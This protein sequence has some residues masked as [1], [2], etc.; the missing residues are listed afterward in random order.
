MHFPAWSI[1]PFVGLLICIAVLPLLPQSARLW[2]RNTVKAAVA[3]GLG[4][5]VAAWVTLRGQSDLVV[6]SVGEYIQFIVLIGALFVVSGG[7]HLDGRIAASPRNNTAILALGGVLASLIGTTGAAMLLIR[8]LLATNAHRK[9]RAHTV[10]FAILVIANCGGLLTPLGDPPLYIGFMR[11]VPFT[12]TLALTGP[13]LFINGMLLLTYYSLDR[14]QWARDPLSAA[15][16]DST[17]KARVRVR[18][19]GNVVWLLV[20]IASVA[21][22]GEQPWLRV[23]VQLAAALGSYLTTDRG[24]RYERNGFTWGP[25][26][27][28]AALFSGIFLTMVPALEFLREHAAALP[29]NEFTLFAFSGGLSA[30]LDNAPTYLT[31]FEMATQL[32]VPG[33]AVIAGV[34]EPYLIAISLGAVTCGAMTYIGN[35]PNFMVKAVAEAAEV[36]MPSFTGYIGWTVRYL[37]PILLCMVLIFIGTSVETTLAG[38][39]LAL[40]LAGAAVRRI[41]RSRGLSV[42]EPVSSTV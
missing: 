37:A 19:A 1:A 9:E 15:V 12:W 16:A 36:K 42:D 13:W 27:E 34:P 38:V 20:I 31:F 6:H 39:A 23:L 28:V 3:L 8:P 5:P 21:L 32:S 14:M 25:I 30:V 41:V 26:I 4:L 18:G 22:L 7:I 40:V 10:V 17:D 24:L 29:L 35:G 33:A 11:G 2:E